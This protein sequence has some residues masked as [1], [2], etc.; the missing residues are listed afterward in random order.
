MTHESSRIKVHNYEI[1][2]LRQVVSSPFNLVTELL[3]GEL[4]NR[5][6]LST[7]SKGHCLRNNRCFRFPAECL[8]CDGFPHW[9][10]SMLF[11]NNYTV[12]FVVSK[13]RQCDY[14]LFP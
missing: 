10:L 11:L 1:L 13:H 12:R 14:S 2:Q 6:N 5:R 7:K 9:G 8:V 3:F 4:S